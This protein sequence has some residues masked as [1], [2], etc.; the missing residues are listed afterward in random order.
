MPSHPEL[1]DWLSIHFMESGW[2][3]KAFQKLIVMSNTYQQSSIASK[4]MYEIDKENRLLTRGPS[5]R[6][7]GEMLRDNALASSGLLNR[8]IGG[9]SVKPYQPD[10]LWSVNNASY[11]QDQG[12]KLYRRSM[13][14]IWKRSVPHPTIATFDTPA[15]S[16]CTT[17]RQETNTPLQALVMLNDPTFIEASRVLGK[18]MLN[19]S[20]IEESIAMTFKQLTGRQIKAQELDILVELQNKE[21][22]KFKENN[23]KIKGWIN[24][25]AFQIKK[26][27]NG[28]LIAAN[29]VVASTIMNSDATITKR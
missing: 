11:K 8:K 10:G 25:G 28:A 6:L 7:S 1:L 20:D 16:V 9:E 3:V 17:R 15:R 29:A 19:Y 12:D 26:S 21:Y 4:N 5:K 23:S 13:Y 14:T 2:D 27:D 24:S 18:K 22:Q